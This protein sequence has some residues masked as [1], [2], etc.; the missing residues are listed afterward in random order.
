VKAG[1]AIGPL[2]IKDHTN[3]RL[4]TTDEQASI[5]KAVFVIQRD[6]SLE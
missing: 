3:K 2:V 4:H 6:Y 5:F 1:P